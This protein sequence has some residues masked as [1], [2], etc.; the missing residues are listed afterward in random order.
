MTFVRSLRQSRRW[1]DWAAFALAVLIAGALAWTTYHIGLLQRQNE[2][3]ASALEQQRQQA[4]DS[5]QEPVA[6]PPDEI[7][8]DPQLVVGPQGPRGPSGY[9]GADGRDGQ[10][11]SPGS[12][13]PTGPPGAQGVAGMGGAPGQAGPPG[14]AGSAGPPG[15]AGPQ[16]EQGPQ[17]DAGPAGAQCPEGT[18][19]ETVT[20]VTTG[21]ARQIA[22]CVEDA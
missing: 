18:H 15:P 2:A 11:G 21:G 6:P 13:G 14:P 12:P 9:P 1:R 22:A 7:L 8:R 17:G 3:L 5:G 19:A 16:G 4:E 10:P 20:V